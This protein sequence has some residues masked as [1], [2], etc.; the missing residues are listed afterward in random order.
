MLVGP[1]G[2]EFVFQL[3]AAV[4]GVCDQERLYG[5]GVVFLPEQTVVVV[6]VA[7]LFADRIGFIFRTNSGG[8]NSG[9]TIFIVKN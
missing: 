7:E 9:D 5:G 2:E 8:A 3:T 6:G 1:V 4:V